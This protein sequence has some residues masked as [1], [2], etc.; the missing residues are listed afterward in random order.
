VR[1]LRSNIVSADDHIAAQL[2]L[3]GSVPGLSV[4]KVI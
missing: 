4:R 2:I 3:K 1:S